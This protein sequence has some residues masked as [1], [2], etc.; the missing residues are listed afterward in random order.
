MLLKVTHKDGILVSKGE[1]M[2]KTTSES[3]IKQ[4]CFF[5]LKGNCSITSGLK[6][7]INDKYK[8][9]CSPIPTCSLGVEVKEFIGKIRTPDENMAEGTILSRYL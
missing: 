3:F 7:E 4:S 5:Y 9:K 2:K 1:L 6:K 8:K